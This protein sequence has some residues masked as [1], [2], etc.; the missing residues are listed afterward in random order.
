[1]KN[2]NINLVY[3]AVLFVLANIMLFLDPLKEMKNMI[4]FVAVLLICSVYASVRF[5]IKEPSDN[6][7]LKFIPKSLLGVFAVLLIITCFIYLK[8]IV[9]GFMAY[10]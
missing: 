7:L 3:S 4:V 2:K 9:I 5:M 10:L 8:M 6:K 1:M